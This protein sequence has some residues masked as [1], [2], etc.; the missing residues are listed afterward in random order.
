MSSGGS[1][2]YSLVIDSLDRVLKL[3]SELASVLGI[4]QEKRT[5]LHWQDIVVEDISGLRPSEGEPAQERTGYLKRASGEILQASFR[6]ELFGLE[7]EFAFVE[8]RLLDTAEST[9]KEPDKDSL[10]F[11]TTVSHELRVALNGVVGFTDLLRNGELTAKQGEVLEKLC[12]CNQMLKNLINDILEYSRVATASLRFRT[13]K[14][15]LKQFVSGVVEQFRQEAKKKDLDLEFESDLKDGYSAVLP[16]MRVTQVLGNLISNAVKFTKKGWVRVKVSGTDESVTFQV[17]DTGKGV[18][19]DKQEEIFRPFFQVSDSSGSIEGSGLGLAIS[20]E[21][22][23][24]MGGTLRLRST[25]DGGSSFEFKLPLG[26]DEPDEKKA[27]PAQ[28]KM[29]FTESRHRPG[30]SRKTALVVED[31]QLNAEILGHFLKDYGVAFD[32]VDNGRSAVEAYEKKAYD[33]VLMDVMLPEMSGYEATEKIIDLGIKT[34][35]QAPIV[36]VTAK[37]FR[38]DRLKCLEVGMVEVV[39]KPVDFHQLR[40]ILDRFLFPDRLEEESSHEEPSDAPESADTYVGEKDDEGYYAL[41]PKV[42][43]EYVN[44]MIT[45]DSDRGEVVASAI[46]I[47]DGEVDGLIEAIRDN[48]RKEVGMRAHSLKGALALLGAVNLLDL[49]KGLELI[50]R[51][52]QAP[53]KAEHWNRL[54]VAGYAEF[55]EELDRHLSS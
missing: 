25:G 28:R 30:D 14:V 6:S 12:S 55:K 51:D 10:E 16:S 22:V 42:L 41:N 38:R 40:G 53:L 46:Q 17:I 35:R 3:P 32:R 18:T 31:N 20:R 27:K 52:R 1:P 37:V 4:S 15:D 36:G 24:K 54:I 23:S 49:A 8:V 2:A 33:L 43:D 44:R 26:S 21:L 11:L 48:N 7:N 13:E 5:K 29:R 50:A 34:G 9:K 47:V 45:S 39:H 19:P